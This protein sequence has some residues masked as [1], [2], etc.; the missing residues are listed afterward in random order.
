MRKIFITFSFLFL[1]FIANAQNVGINI[2]TPQA[3]LDVY[4]DVIFR[5]AD[6]VAA[7]GVN[8]AL[9]VNYNRFSFYRIAGPTANFSIGGITAG[10]EGRLVTLFNRS[11][12]SMQLNNEDPAATAN[13]RIIT[14]T[15]GD[16]VIDQ[17]G[18]VNLQYD[19]AEQR[20][21]VI[22]NNKPGGSVSGGWGLNGNAGINPLTDFI[23]STDNQPFIIKSNNQTVAEFRYGFPSNNYIGTNF[24]RTGIGIIGTGAPTHTL[25]VGLADLAGG[26]QGAFGIRGTNF[27]THFNYGATEDVYIRGGKNGSHILLNDLNG[28]GNV[29]IGTPYLPNRKLEL[30][31][32]RMLFSGAQDPGNNIYAGIE[33]T[34]GTGSTL[35]GFM[36]MMNDNYIGFYG[37]G[38]ANFGMVMNVATGNVGIGTTSPANK[39]S[40]NGDIR[41][42]EVTVEIVNWPD[43]V[44][45]DQYT[46]PDLATTSQYIATH[47]H[48]PG[49]PAAAEIEKNGLQLG[50]MQK[51]MMEKIEELTLYIIRQQQEIDQLKKI[52][53]NR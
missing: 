25:E 12:F 3:T 38:G 26:S 20:W 37:Y 51:R 40:V 44:F 46:L 30:Y 11:G 33:F 7:D 2:A 5:S 35:R 17:K 31:K 10:V 48:L 19:G 47:K 49:V 52:I 16:L 32:G 4:G 13:D 45:H 34:N 29:G 36:G 18:I 43:Y 6:I 23:G 1:T 42:R 21:L 8:L 28:L 22:S 39:L 41:S 27:M 14:G 15:N 9:D 24:Q 53:H 50:D